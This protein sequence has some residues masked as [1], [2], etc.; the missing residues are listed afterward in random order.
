MVLGS[1]FSWLKGQLLL[2]LLLQGL[3]SDGYFSDVEQLKELI[4]II[5][6]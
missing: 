5:S 2:L 1:L 3:H 6:Q 4:H